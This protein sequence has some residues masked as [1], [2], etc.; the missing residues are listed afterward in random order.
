M[1]H[2]KQ[3]ADTTQLGACRIAI[4]KHTAG[5]VSLR[6]FQSPRYQKRG[7][8]TASST[9]YPFYGSHP[10]GKCL[11]FEIHGLSHGLKPCHWHGFFTTFRVPLGT[12]K[13]DALRRPLFW[14]ERWDSNPH[15]V[16][17]RTSNVLVYHSNTLASAIVLYDFNPILSRLFSVFIQVFKQIYSQNLPAAASGTRD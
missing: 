12:K 3:D 16:T 2:K 7:H 1:H 6:P 11:R 14:C 15:G 10:T 8:L 9:F 5:M 4:Y 17:T 13:E